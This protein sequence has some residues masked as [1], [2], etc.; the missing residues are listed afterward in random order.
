[1]RINKRIQKKCKKIK[2]KRKIY[3]KNTKT[4]DKLIDESWAVQQ[5]S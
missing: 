4:K 5:V 1:M 2:Q 3:Q